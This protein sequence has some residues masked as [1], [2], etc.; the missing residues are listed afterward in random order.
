[1]ERPRPDLCRR[2]R[3]GDGILAV[4]ALSKFA[5]AGRVPFV[6]PTRR[7]VTERLTGKTEERAG[8]WTVNGSNPQDASISYRTRLDFWVWRNA[9]FLEASSFKYIFWH[10]LM[11][12]WKHQSPPPHPHPILLLVN[13]LA[14][15]WWFVCPALPPWRGL[16]VN[17]PMVS[18]QLP[19]MW[20]AAK[21]D[22]WIMG[23]L[24]SASAGNAGCLQQLLCLRLKAC[25]SHSRREL[26][27]S[28]P[29]S[30][31]T[32]KHL[33]CDEGM[34]PVGFAVTATNRKYYSP[35]SDSFMTVRWTSSLKIYIKMLFEGA[36]IL[37][38]VKPGRGKGL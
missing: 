30:L 20:R 16:L 12:A 26:R 29:S 21:E 7:P 25:G 22:G 10:A 6:F 15:Q 28:L 9:V 3:F 38:R 2:P 18:L 31:V 27:L 24:S 34:I 5:T 32:L 19:L 17:R 11:L 33:G 36:R 8:S 37:I 23:G 14:G 13:I 1:M 4:R 35:A